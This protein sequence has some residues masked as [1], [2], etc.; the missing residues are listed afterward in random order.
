MKLVSKSQKVLFLFSHYYYFFL[1]LQDN[2]LVEENKIADEDLSELALHLELRIKE[3][4]EFITEFEGMVNMHSLYLYKESG[5][6]IVIVNIK[7]CEF[8]IIFVY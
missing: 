8:C 4:N 7:A 5:A 6:Y 3:E 1:T 2:Y